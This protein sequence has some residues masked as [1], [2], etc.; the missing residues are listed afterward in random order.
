MH[1][2]GMNY[3]FPISWTNEKNT[4]QS[5][6]KVWTGKEAVKRK[7]KEKA[8]KRKSNNKMGK[9]KRSCDWNASDKRDRAQRSG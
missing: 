2:I 3:N 7:I 5:E 1:C 8:V 9:R 4:Q 6:K